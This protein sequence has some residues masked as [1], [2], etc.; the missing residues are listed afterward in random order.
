MQRQQTTS[1]H[2]I[3][4]LALKSTIDGHHEMANTAK[5]QS[6]AVALDINT[7]HKN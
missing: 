6:K 3:T 1:D 2:E 4:G 7:A 5:Q